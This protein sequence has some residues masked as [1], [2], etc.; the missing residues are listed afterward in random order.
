MKA[1]LTKWLPP[2]EDFLPTMTSAEQEL[3]QQHG[4]WLTGMMDKGLVAHGPVIDP[5]GGYGVALWQIGDDADIAA[6]TAQ[7]PIIV[8]GIGRYEHF[9]MVQLKTRG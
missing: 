2:R 6:L 8:A 1:Y 4:A 5:A 3:M 9:P 7:D